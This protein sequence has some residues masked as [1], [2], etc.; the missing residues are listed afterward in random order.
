MR[1]DTSKQKD[2][3]REMN[4]TGSDVP[5]PVPTYFEFHLQYI[6]HVL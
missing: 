3:W 4:N 5:L 2:K 6:T 1:T